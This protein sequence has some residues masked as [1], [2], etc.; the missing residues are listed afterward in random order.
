MSI[1]AQQMTCVCALMF[2]LLQ[3]LQLHARRCLQ[4][5]QRGGD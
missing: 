3:L 4:Q 5:P 2:A 1:I